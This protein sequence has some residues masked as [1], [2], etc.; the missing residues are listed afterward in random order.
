MIRASA[1]SALGARPV[2]YGT[3]ADYRKLS[4]DQRLYFQ[5]YGKHRANAPRGWREEQEWRIA[6]DVLLEKLPRED[7]Q[8]FVRTRCEALQIARRFPW[9]VFWFAN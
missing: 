4:D 2:V 9:S 6:G 5:P 8:L 3:E 7:V 1:L